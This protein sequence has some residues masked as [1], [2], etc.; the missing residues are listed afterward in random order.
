LYID[1]AQVTTKVTQMMAYFPVLEPLLAQRKIPSDF[2]FL[3]LEDSLFVDN[4]ASTGLWALR[5]EA[6]PGLRVDATIDERL[7][8][9]AAST[10]AVTVLERLH[11]QTGNWVAALYRYR[12][13]EPAPAMASANSAIFS[14]NDDR[15]APVIRFLAH[16]LVLERA[17][18]VY[19]PKRQLI[20]YPYDE[21]QGRSLAELADYFRINLNELISY[22]SWLKG[23]RVPSDKAY[24]IFIPATQ[25][26]YPDVKRRAAGADAN[27]TPRQ[28]AGF[29]VLQKLADSGASEG[30]FFQINGRNGIQAQLYD[31]AI[32]LA[33]KGKVKLKSFMRYNDL[34][35]DQ[36][37]YA[38]EIYYLAKKDSRGPV[39]FHITR[40]G[41]SLWE[42]S[43]QYGVQLKALIRYNAINP[44]QPLLAG[45]ILWLQKN[46]PKSTPVEYYRAP[47]PPTKPMSPEPLNLSPTVA[48]KEPNPATKAPQFKLQVDS[49]IITMTHTAIP[50]RPDSS[51]KLVA[52][53]GP[54]AIRT[55][56]QPAIPATAEPMAPK[57][58]VK[59]LTVK[60]AEARPLLMHVVEK[61]ETYAT[62]ARRY[63]VSVQQ[64]LEWNHLVF[65]KPLRPGQALLIDTSG[66]LIRAVKAP[67]LPKPEAKVPLARAPVSVMSPLD[68][69]NDARDL[70]H[71]VKPG[72]NLYRV[73]MRYRVTPLQVQRWNSLT[74][75]V[76]E[77]GMKLVI[78]NRK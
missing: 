30:T 15:A 27:Q 29:P 12:I 46:R 38:G 44:E 2:R 32:T 16:K 23:S 48:V 37:I 68:T 52:S 5:K 4:G 19:K 35:D 7:H 61:G 21:T 55:P 3:A 73:A 72:E 11:A 20:L 58:V 14:L 8:P 47:E 10:A 17:F 74:S 13:G 31:K 57:A 9:M 77:V 36:P 24:T 78:K 45:R 40:R 25:E 1:R 18:S 50:V 43:Q 49:A 53:S 41:Q 67:V 65:Q 56:T 71:V 64:V 76:L 63:R 70:L 75:Q 39:P 6:S 22:N 28:D 42:V 69:F 59:T 54:K 51:V 34:R 60:A 66:E 26:Q 33:Y 62:V